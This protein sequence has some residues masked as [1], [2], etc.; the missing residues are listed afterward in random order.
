M[1]DLSFRFQQSS[2]SLTSPTETW[3]NFYT[4]SE[5]CHL[6]AIHPSEW[7]GKNQATAGDLERL[8]R[9]VIPQ[10]PTYLFPSIDIALNWWMG[11]PDSFR[12]G[13]KETLPLIKR[14]RSSNPFR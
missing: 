13:E 6:F 10:S 9:H 12:I 3:F 7:D 14:I 2:W 8:K 1:A 5:P 11:H 4:E